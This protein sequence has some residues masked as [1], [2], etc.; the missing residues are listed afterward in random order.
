MGKY[1]HIILP[2]DINI[3]WHHACRM[4]GVDDEVKV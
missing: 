1:V 4:T 2:K 3:I